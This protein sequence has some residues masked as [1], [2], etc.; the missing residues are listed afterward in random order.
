MSGY[1]PNTAKTFSLT[2]GDIPVENVITKLKFLSKVKPGEKINV[3]RLFV[4][5]DPDTDWYQWF[6]RS[7]TTIVAGGESKEETHDFIKFIYNETIDLICVY[8]TEPT[9]AFKQSIAM[10]LVK[11]LQ[12]SK[13]GIESLKLTYAGDKFE[14]QI[15]AIVE[16]TEARLKVVAA[17]Q[18][19]EM[20]TGNF[21]NDSDNNE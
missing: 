13:P 14:S 8:N 1:T 12:A 9:D 2:G 4:R 11:N 5:A 3:K 15:D 19:K 10:M 17:K 6:L 18:L 20:D 16:T 7:C 21:G